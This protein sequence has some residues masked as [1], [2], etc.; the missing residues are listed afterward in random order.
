MDILVDGS[1]VVAATVILGFIL[2]QAVTWAGLELSELAKKLIVFAVAVAITGYSAYRGGLPVP[3]TGDP[4]TFAAYLLAA[5]GA[6]FK[7]A[8][9]IYDTIWQ[10]LVRAK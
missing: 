3:P 1:L 7:V 10:G 4:M 2:N 9:P 5:A 6:V 8:Q